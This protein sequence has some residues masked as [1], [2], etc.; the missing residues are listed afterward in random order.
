[1]VTLEN[2]FS[3]RRTPVKKLHG[4]PATCKIGLSVIR[5]LKSF[6]RYGLNVLAKSNTLENIHEAKLLHPIIAFDE[7]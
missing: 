1:V 2:V 7:G 5:S 4:T 3:L 6:S